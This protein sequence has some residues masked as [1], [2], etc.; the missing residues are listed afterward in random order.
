[1]SMWHTT[2]C[3]KGLLRLT[4]IQGFQPLWLGRE[5]VF[6]IMN[7]THCWRN[8]DCCSVVFTP[9]RVAYKRLTSHC[10]FWGSMINYCQVWKSAV[11]L[12]LTYHCWRGCWSPFVRFLL[13][14][15]KTVQK[16]RGKWETMNYINTF[17][18]IVMGKTRCGTDFRLFPVEFLI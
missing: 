12:P 2:S 16:C 8:V 5:E 7:D 10:A 13:L 9:S 6:H 3:S 4:H 15:P 11:C 18:E 14:Q 17:P 1:M